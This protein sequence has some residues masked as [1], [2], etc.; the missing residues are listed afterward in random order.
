[1]SII[2]SKRFIKKIALVGD[3]AVGK[4]SL[5]RR[6]VIDVFDDKY[7]ATIGAKVVKRD[8]EFKLPEKTV[9]LTLVIWDI[10]GQKDYNKMRTQGITGSSGVILVTDLSRPET[11]GSAEG[12]WLKELKKTV[13]SAPLL[14]AG[15]KSD[16]AEAGSGAEQL[17]K[18]SQRLAIPILLTSAKTGDN[19][20]AAFRQIGEMMLATEL[21]KSSAQKSEV[22]LMSAVDEVVS[23][24]C[25]QYGDTSAAME[26]VDREFTR[27]HV[28]LNAPSKDSLLMAL[29][30]L[31]DVERDILGRDVSEVNKLRRWKMIDEAL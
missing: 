8:L 9:Y 13:P 28:D 20:A 19:V 4:T 27:A 12:F 24:F 5:V 2:K 29:E 6:F 15:N 18:M 7:I 10:L 17:K 26:I 23:D 30:Y 3:T 22:S 31:S 25:E 11:I 14:I 21:E 16:L 1:M